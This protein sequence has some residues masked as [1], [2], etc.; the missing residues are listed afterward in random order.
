MIN[1]YYLK[2]INIKQ[3]QAHSCSFIQGVSRLL[4][5]NKYPYSSHKIP[6]L[7]PKQSQIGSIHTE[8]NTS[9]FQASW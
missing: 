4:W 5:K 7:L 8:K 2:N 6:R 3:T 9:F 1:T